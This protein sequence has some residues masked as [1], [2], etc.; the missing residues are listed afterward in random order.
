MIFTIFTAEQKELIIEIVD[1]EQSQYTDKV[2][3]ID[4]LTDGWGKIEIKLA[5][6]GFATLITFEGRVFAKRKSLKIGNFYLNTY[7]S[8]FRDAL[9][10]DKIRDF[11][12][13]LI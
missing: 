11:G 7:R 2:S 12:V 4:Y 10:L 3:K 8:H 9:I 1:R 6:I 5:N 13:S